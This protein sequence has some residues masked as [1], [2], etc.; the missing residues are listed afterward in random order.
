MKLHVTNTSPFARQTRIVVLET[1]LEDRVEMVE[2]NPWEA[3]SGLGEINPQEKVPALVLDD[4]RVM[5][6]NQ[7]ISQYLDGLHG[8]ARLVPEDEAGRF[9]VLRLT[10]L[11]NGAIEASVLHIIEV[12]RRPEGLRW[13]A[14]IDRQR[15]KVERT[16]DLFEREIDGLGDP[17]A[18]APTNLA[19]IAVGALLGYLDFRFPD[20]PW[21][22]NRPKLA[23]WYERFARRPSMQATMPPA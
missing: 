5:T 16:L 14:W 10:A 11:A 23:A 20:L 15:R 12:M 7:L 22:P 9:E 6:E 21:R 13:Q 4:G 18:D 3:E 1:G 2:S 19:Q 8:G 17:A